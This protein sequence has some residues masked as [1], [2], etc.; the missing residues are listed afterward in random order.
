MGNSKPT[1][2][3]LFCGA[4][5]IDLG[6]QNAGLDIIWANDNDK[7]S[8]DTYRKNVDTRVVLDDV[9]NIDP[10]SIP[11]GD[12]LV[13]GFPCQGFSVANKF[14]SNS[15]ERN[16]LY[17]EMLRLIKAKKPKWFVAE[18][19]KGILSLDKGAVFKMILDD[20]ERTGYRVSY[21]VVNMADHGVPQTRQRVIILGTRKDLPESLDA[22]HPIRTHS[23]DS[24]KDGLIE[25]VT[26]GQALK[27]LEQYDID[28]DVSSSYKVVDRNFTGH[29]KTNPDKP[30]PT[31]LA[32]GNGGGGVNATPHPYLPRR[33]SV[34]E[35]AIIQS[36]PH[37][38]RFCGSMTS[39][40]RQIGNAVPV[41]YGEKLGKMF[42]DISRKSVNAKQ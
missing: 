2:I 4:G 13:G 19:V 42:V 17:T 25:W 14:R 21:E 32:R 36:F 29:R 23:K 30:S 22:Y 27:K 37:T 9:K 8:V 33:L 20:F 40:Y 24:K 6:L 38:F 3:S 7:D 10:K 34:M 11:D 16:E 41:L 31:I 39:Q 35:S 15:D 28:H 5:G 12:I 1:V 26:M 18:N